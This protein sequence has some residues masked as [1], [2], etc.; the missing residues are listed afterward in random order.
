[1]SGALRLG[2]NTLFYL[3]CKVGGSETYVLETLRALRGRPEPPVLVLYTD[4]ENHDLLQREFPEAAHLPV[5]CAVQ[6]DPVGGYIEGVWIK[7]QAAEELA[8]VAWSIGL[9]MESGGCGCGVGRWRARADECRCITVEAVDSEKQKQGRGGSKHERGESQ[10]PAGTKPG[11]L[12]RKN[13]HNFIHS[14][15]F[16]LKR[17]SCLCR[18]WESIYYFF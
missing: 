9:H 7:R 12:S 1:M 3:P 4:D 13:I 15:L 16:G 5:G 17:L 2:V 11:L 8:V 18:T 14:L 10:W 6:S